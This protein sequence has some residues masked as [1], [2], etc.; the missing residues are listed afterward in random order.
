MPQNN[1]YFKIGVF[2]FV[3]MGLFLAGLLAFGLIDSMFKENLECVTYFNRSVQGLAADSPV[4]F[5]GFKVGKVTAITLASMEDAHGQPV[6]KVSF[7]IDPQTLAGH[8]DG[9]NQARDYLVRQA[10]QGMR[11]ILTFQGI[12]GIGFLDLDYQA[13]FKADELTDSMKQRA[14]VQHVVYIP[15]GPGQ[16]MEIG[17]SV[18]TLVK[19]LSDVDFAGISRDVRTLVQTVDKTAAD[20]N[21]GQISA[22][23]AAT[24]NEIRKSATDLGVLIDDISSTVK[25]GAKTNI[26]Q[27]LEAS[28]QQLRQTLKRL[29][30]V[31]G[32][33]QGNLPVTLDNLRVM[34]ENFRELSELL[35]AQPSQAIFGGPPAA[36]NPTTVR[37]SASG[38]LSGPK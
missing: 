35:K 37:N 24:L 10:D 34:S 36:S 4:K 12:T 7:E 33:S 2:T 23:L 13:D 26:G 30:Q 19:S 14:A 28:V 32:S 9:L 25:G 38:K 22:D 20:L 3:G 21:T 5:R 27:E 8:T 11:A 15:S 18:A 16:I 6:V 1:N 17:E 29:D 31:L